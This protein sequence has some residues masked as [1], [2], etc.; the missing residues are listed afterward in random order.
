M[1]PPLISSDIWLLLAIAIGSS[2]G[3][4]TYRDII[5]AG[6]AINHA[7]FTHEELEGGLYKLL[8]NKLIVQSENG[9]VTTDKANLEIE[10]AKDKARGWLA[11]WDLLKITFD[12]E[13]GPSP[14]EPYSFPGYSVEEVER[15]IAEYHADMNELT[16]K[17]LQK[18]Q[19]ISR[20]EAEQQILKTRQWH[21]RLWDKL[22]R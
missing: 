10:R 8:Q 17:T 13:K 2:D 12:I 1:T 18:E 11:A 14:S 7:I 4:A 16:I 9:F 19:G 20:H 5:S 15:T 6:D 21:R 3:E 22:K